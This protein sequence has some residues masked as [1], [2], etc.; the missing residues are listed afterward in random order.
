MTY[1]TNSSS[2]SEETGM[3]VKQN[4]EIMIALTIGF[5]NTYVWKAVSFSP[6]RT[7]SLEA[8]HGKA[9]SVEAL[10]IFLRVTYTLGN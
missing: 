2:T 3:R 1:L 6:L 10:L 7:D 8:A 4:E 5:K 9:L